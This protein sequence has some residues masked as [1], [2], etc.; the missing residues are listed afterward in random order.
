MK[1]KSLE[2]V[3]TSPINAWN[4][5]MKPYVDNVFYVYR[6]LRYLFQRL[7]IKFSE[8]QD[9]PKQFG[10]ICSPNFNIHYAVDISIMATEIFRTA[11]LFS[12][13]FQ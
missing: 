7:A 10:M 3:I 11:S 2:N 12:S 1:F 5:F 4:I 13:L 9:I 6:M 8:P